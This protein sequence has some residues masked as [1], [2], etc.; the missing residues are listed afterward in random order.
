MDFKVM[1]ESIVGNNITLKVVTDPLM[2]TVTLGQLDQLTDKIKSWLEARAFEIEE[3]AVTATREETSFIVKM[4]KG[5][6]PGAIDVACGRVGSIFHY[7]V[8]P[9]LESLIRQPALV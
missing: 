8:A 3:V 2:R 9:E 7:R 4:Y 1:C 6:F 5:S